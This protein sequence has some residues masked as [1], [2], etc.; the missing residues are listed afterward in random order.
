M[1]EAI[2]TLQQNVFSLVEEGRQALQQGM[3]DLAPIEVA[4]RAFCEALQ[5]LPLEEAK[6]FA[7]TLRQL[8]E[9]MHVLEDE[10]QRA[11]WAVQQQLTNL[12][13][14]RQAETAYRTTDSMGEVIRLP[15]SDEEEGL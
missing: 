14:I 8:S 13:R 12:N 7:P 2:L 4:V 10:L 1:S 5:A 15:G 3:V 9:N 11:R 6:E